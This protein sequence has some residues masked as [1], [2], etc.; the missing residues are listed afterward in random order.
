MYALSNGNPASAPVSRWNVATHWSPTCVSTRISFDASAGSVTRPTLI[1][2]VAAFGPAAGTGVTIGCVGG[3][4]ALWGGR[5]RGGGT[6]GRFAVGSGGGLPGTPGTAFTGG[7]PLI[8]AVTGVAFGY[9]NPRS[10]SRD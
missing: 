3:G 4:R 8:A 10:D 7:P 2:G 9:W 5:V 1:S 6:P